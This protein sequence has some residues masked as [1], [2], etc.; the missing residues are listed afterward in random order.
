MGDYDPLKVVGCAAALALSAL[1]WLV[2]VRVALE[3][4]RRAGWS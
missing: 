1:G 3:L 2:I 4:A